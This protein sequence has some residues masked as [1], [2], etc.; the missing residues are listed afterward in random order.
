M[1]DWLN[2]L[3]EAKLERADKFIFSQGMYKAYFTWF[4]QGFYQY[5]MKGKLADVWT[6]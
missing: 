1:H 3:S 5:L 6:I 4:F 2:V